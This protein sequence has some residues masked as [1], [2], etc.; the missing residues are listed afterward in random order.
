MTSF[1]LRKSS[2]IVCCD[3][4]PSARWYGDRSQFTSCFAR[5]VLVYLTARTVGNVL[6]TVSVNIVPVK[7]LLYCLNGSFDTQV[8][9]IWCI[10]EVPE[11]QTSNAVV[12]GYNNVMLLPPKSFKV[13]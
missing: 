13:A 2:D 9:N 3:G 8:S 5:E 7:V 10:M 1:S 11:D 4:K 12:I 6:S